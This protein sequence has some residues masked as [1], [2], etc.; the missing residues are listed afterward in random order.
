M[1]AFWNNKR[2]ETEEPS[3][4]SELL[5]LIIYILIVV[6][7]IVVIHLY[8]GERTEVSGDSM[9]ETLQDGDSLWL[10][11]LTYHFQDPERYDIVVFPHT[12]AATGNEVLYVK[13]IIG[14][15]GETIA[16]TDN[17]NILVN[18]K[19]L[20]E[21]YGKETIDLYHIG[22]ASEPITLGEDEY[23][24]MGDNRNNSKDSRDAEV[25]NISRDIIEGRV[26][27]RMWPWKKI[28]T[29]K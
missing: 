28:G 4:F 22:V 5:G 19:A 8:V 9:N 29:V 10:D 13:R 24:V 11:K 2:E 7:L 17:G 16:I 23:F 15:P 6:V 20:E 27:F 26:V 21:S 14:L 1:V 12:D 25:G 18:G 3:V